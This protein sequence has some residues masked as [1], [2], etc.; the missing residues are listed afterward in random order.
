MIADTNE[1]NYFRIGIFVLVGITLIVFALLVF[2][3]RKLLEPIV[4]VETYFEESVQGISEGTPVKYRGLQ[5]GYITDIAFSS[6]IYREIVAQPSSEQMHARSI[7]VRIAITSKLFTQLKS[8]ALKAFLTSEI[9][10]GLRIRIITQGLTGTSYLELDYVD[11]KTNPMIPVAWQPQ[12]FYIPS[13]TSNLTKL[14]ENARY[15]MNELKDINFK[16]LFLHIDTLVVS[17]NRLTNRTENLLDYIDN[18]L[19]ELIKELK[20]VT[21]NI[22]EVSRRIKLRPSEIIFGSSPPPL[23]PNK[24]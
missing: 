8:E 20:I 17:L 19:I 10:N 9:V 22:G 24:L 23:D 16:R 18:P 6:E 3:S 12:V 2:G 13:V 21:S 15:I 5:I 4:Y 7:Y 1:T 11:P 14:S